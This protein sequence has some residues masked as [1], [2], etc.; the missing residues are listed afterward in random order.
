MGLRR[1]VIT[2]FCVR[3]TPYRLAVHAC[4]PS[5]CSPDILFHQQKTRAEN[6]VRVQ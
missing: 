4:V 6:P 2:S 1:R 3:S 5:R